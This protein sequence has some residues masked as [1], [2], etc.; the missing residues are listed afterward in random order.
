[1]S[2]PHVY[3]LGPM[4]GYPEDN[5]PAFKAA[6]EQLRRDGFR[7]TCP[8]ELDTADPA[9]GEDWIAL[10]RRD[11]PHLLIVEGGVALPGWRNS[12][13][14]TLEATIL[15]ALGKPVFQWPT[16]QVIAPEDLPE[17]THPHTPSPFLQATVR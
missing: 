11:I 3:I 12:R 1:M 13:G 9:D 15:R 5:R 10:M 2:K 14:A 7:V 16:M 17:P 4:T 6:K 8:D